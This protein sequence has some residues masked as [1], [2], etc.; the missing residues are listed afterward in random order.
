MDAKYCDPPVKIGTTPFHLSSRCLPRHEKTAE[1]PSLVADA[2]TLR[3]KQAV[4]IVRILGSS[5]R[6]QVRYG[7]DGSH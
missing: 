4:E 5:V 7:D 2:A 1:H 6:L 3:C